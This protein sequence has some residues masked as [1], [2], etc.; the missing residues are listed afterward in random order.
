MKEMQMK[1]FSELMEKTQPSAKAFV[2]D[3]NQLAKKVEMLAPFMEN[4]KEVSPFMAEK[5][6]QALGGVNL[7]YMMC[8]SESE[9]MV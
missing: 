3:Y 9:E 2:D 7:I 8:K 6:E 5:M 4:K 1:A